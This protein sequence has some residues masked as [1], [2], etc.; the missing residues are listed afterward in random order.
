MFVHVSGRTASTSRIKKNNLTLKNEL[1][2]NKLAANFAKKV[3]FVC[4]INVLILDTAVVTEARHNLSKKV[5]EKQTIWYHLA[6]GLN[7]AVW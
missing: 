7:A 1:V 2:A 5:W 3:D 6:V 4:F